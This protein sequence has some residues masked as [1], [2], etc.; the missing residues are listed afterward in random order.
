VEWSTLV[1]RLL[2]SMD[3]Q[4]DDMDLQTDDMDLQTDVMHPIPMI[5]SIEV[6][7][8]SD[9]TSRTRSIHII[10]QDFRLAIYPTKQIDKQIPF[11]DRSLV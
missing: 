5:E 2:G 4:T 8:E 9:L 10:P 1:K 11:T 3:L 6:T 7:E